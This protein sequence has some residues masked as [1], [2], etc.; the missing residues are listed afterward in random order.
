MDLQI[1]GGGFGCLQ[2]VIQQL[3]QLLGLAQQHLGILRY[4]LFSLLCGL[5]ADTVSDILR[6]TGR[7]LP[8]EIRIID[9]GRQWSLDVMGHIRD[10]LRLQMFTLHPLLHGC[11][12]PLAD[13]VQILSVLLEGQ[14]H[15]GGIQLMIQISVRQCF[16]ALLQFFAHQCH[17]SN[18]TAQNKFLYGPE[19]E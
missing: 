14:Y 6:I 9:N 19:K 8:D 11:G 17:K 4:M 15:M 12:N 7:F 1:A 13:A 3:F 5:C 18:R 10:Q 16:T 2:Q